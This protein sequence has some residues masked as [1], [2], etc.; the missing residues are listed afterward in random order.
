MKRVIPRGPLHQKLFIDLKATMRTY[1]LRS[2]GGEQKDSQKGFC[3]FFKLTFP[4]K[5]NSSL[6]Y[7]TNPQTIMSKEN[8]VNKPTK[9]KIKTPKTMPQNVCF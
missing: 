2:Y 9:I 1:E 6:H 5:S 7:E 3:P 4:W 8:Y